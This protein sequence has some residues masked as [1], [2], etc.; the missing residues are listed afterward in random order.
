MSLSSHLRIVKVGGSLFEFDRLADALKDWLERQ[1][2][3]V[4]VLLAGG[5][6]LVNFLR[7]ADERLKLGDE[8]AHWLSIDAMDLTARILARLLPDASLVD[9]FASIERGRSIVSPQIVFVASTF[10]R[11]EE[12]HLP[13]TTLPHDWTVTSDS[14]A[15]RLAET[16]QADELNLLKSKDPMCE[17]TS[18]D[19]AAGGLVDEHFPLAA[20]KLPVVRW[21]NLRADNYRECLAERRD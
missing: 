21:V 10:L 7:R 2:P 19:W 18:V 17:K 12:P 6:P 1:P 16:L 8:A 13:G 5:G 4:T 15:A 11:K 14:I 20:A 3:A 9:D